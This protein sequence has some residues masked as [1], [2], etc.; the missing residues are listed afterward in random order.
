MNAGTVQV[1]ITP[2]AGEHYTLEK[3]FLVQQHWRVAID[4]LYAKVL[5]LEQDGRKMCILSADI[6]SIDTR[7]RDELRAV[8]AEC[9]IAPQ[10]VMCHA[11]QN[12]SCP[13]LG[14]AKTTMEFFREPA[15]FWAELTSGDDAYREY[16]MERMCQAIRDANAALA[17]AGIGAASGVEGRVAFNR[18]MITKDGSVSMPLFMDR[19]DYRYLEGPIDPELG[20][21]CIRGQ[22]LQPLAM[23]VNYT[24]H[25]VNLH[26]KRMEY[27]ISA[28]WPGALSRELKS[29]YG[30]A[31][32]PL[33]L[34]GACGN[35]NPW[36]PWDPDFVRD[37][38]RMGK[39]LAGT[40]ELTID[41]IL[42]ED[43]VTLDWATRDLQLPWDDDPAQGLPECLAFIKKHPEPVWADETHTAVDPQ[44][45]NAAW[46][47]ETHRL[48]EAGA[49]SPYEI[50]VL[51]IND[52]AIVALPGEPFVEA[53]LE[54]KLA[55][56]AALTYVVHMPTWPDG[57]Y[58]PTQRAYANGGYETGHNVCRMPPG[59][60]ETITAEAIDLLKE[61]FAND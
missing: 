18:R 17:P 60:L 8:A 1:D 19:A 45:V 48:A 21:V 59:T 15:A 12:H 49:M 29:I 2:L 30:D 50:Q 58:L 41:E 31:C 43:N 16:A 52:V 51:R 9:G 23:L 47:V 24:A 4:P 25:P 36:D 6:N 44:W 3:N 20:V 33:V 40:A 28:D 54:I 56:P 5:I 53:G 26:P 34:N 10:A 39:L 27:V 61:T 7:C 32:T 46:R 38:K 11:L 55:S 22:S 35:I 42:Y 37:H 57:S 13:Q 14:Y